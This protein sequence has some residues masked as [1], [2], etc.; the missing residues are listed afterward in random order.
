MP[1]YMKLSMRRQFLSSLKDH[2]SLGSNELDLFR[3][4]V[5]ETEEISGRMEAEERKY[6]QEQIDAGV[7]EFNDS[8]MLVVDYYRETMRSSHVVFLTSLLEGALKRECNR[9]VLAL[10]EQILFKPTELKGEVWS[11]RKLFL[12]KY[13]SFSTP[14]NLWNPILE[15]LAVRNAFVHHSGDVSLLATKQV[16]KLNKIKYINVDSAYVTIEPLFIDTSLRAV[17]ELTDFLHKKTGE[18]IDR[19]IS[20]N[21]V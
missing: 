12:E 2:Y 7:E 16:G 1:K 6:I 14:E 11:S 10:G 9:I 20:P 18:L 17:R 8:G 21:I 3:W 15:L 5:A 13:C 19:A 4:F